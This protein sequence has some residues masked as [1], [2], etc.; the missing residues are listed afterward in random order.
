MKS[1]FKFFDKDND[2]Q[3][4]FQELKETLMEDNLLIED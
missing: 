3:I 1:A 4:S 2:E